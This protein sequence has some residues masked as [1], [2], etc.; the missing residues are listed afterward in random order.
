MKRLAT[1]AVLITFLLVVGCTS[2]G[3]T[4]TLKTFIGG[5]QGVSIAFDKNAPPKEVFDGGDFP[6][7]IALKIQNKGEYAVPAANA[8]V[9]ITG[10]RPQEFNLQEAD[11]VKSPPEDLIQRKQDSTGKTTEPG[12]VFVEFNKFNHVGFITG[13]A[14]EYPIRA[15]ICY[16]YGTTATSSLC[17]RK[18]LANPEE[19]GICTIDGS[20]P[21]SISGA[22][23]QITDVKEFQ[24]GKDS[25][26][27]SFTVKNGNTANGKV[28]ARNSRCEGGRS[29]ED[30]IFASV[31]TD[32]PGLTCQGLDA[33]GEGTVEGT[34][35]T[36]A[37]DRTVTCTQRVASP[38]D[39]EMPI[40]IVLSYDY[41][42]YVETTVTV[43]HSGDETTTT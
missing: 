16:L 31:K 35:S 21:L 15:E 24:R 12:D 20:R 23:V 11:L 29:V 10:I 19:N 27:F 22:P 3:K 42:D 39:Y 5:T 17:I 38:S 40:T 32:I 4:V 2:G 33:T 41:R 9:S 13:N 8:K 28:F 6:F 37:Q 18:N 25:I 36:F 14:L 7:D 34:I 43:K 26:G 30:R 1:F